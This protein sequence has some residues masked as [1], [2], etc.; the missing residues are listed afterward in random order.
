MNLCGC[1]G[2]HNTF[3]YCTTVNENIPA[4]IHTYDVHI[5][6][7]LRTI[8]C[9]WY[10]MCEFKLYDNRYCINMIFGE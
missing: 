1:A 5:K 6:P 10:Y 4:Y 9:T 3:I 2:V 8:E 7:V